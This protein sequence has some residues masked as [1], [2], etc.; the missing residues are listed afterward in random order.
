MRADLVT[1]GKTL[2]G[3][4]PVG[5]VGGRAGLMRRFR[6][7]RPADVCFARGTF[8]SHPYVMTAMNEF[9]Q[10]VDRPEVRAGYEGIDA[11]WDG[12]AR[13]LNERLAARGLPQRLANLTSVWTTLYTQPGHYAW[14]FQYY[15]RRHGIATSWVGSGRFIFSHDFT[16]ADCAEFAD[17]FVA[18]AEAMQQDGWWWSDG[19]LTNAGIKRRV[20]KEL[21]TVGLFGRRRRNPVALTA[22][23]PEP[24]N[25]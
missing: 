19:R 14:M 9:L 6:E 21:L 17:R 18:A 5:V 24:V 22:P 1:Y 20:L 7:A 12:R 16:D 3:G 23:V 2:G 10:H 13:A 8:N 15:L 11:L 25:A 4:L